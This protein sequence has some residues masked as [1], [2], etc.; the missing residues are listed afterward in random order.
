MLP[1]DF[2]QQHLDRVSRSFAFC[3]AELK[4]D[5]RVWVSLS[6]L[7]FRILD[8][9]E[10][11][12]WSNPLAKKAAFEDFLLFLKS[13]PPPSD[14]ERWQK[15]F[16]DSLSGGEAALIQVSD[17][18]FKDFDQ[19]DPSIRQDIFRSAQIMCH[20]M[21]HYAQQNPL[22]LSS[23]PEVNR[24]CFFVA[25]IVG[26]LL[27]QLAHRKFDFQAPVDTIYLNS[28]HF[29]L[30][31]QKTNLLKDQ[32]TDERAER[33]LIPNRSQIVASL[34]RN[35]KG[36]FDYICAIPLSAKEYRLFCSWSLFLGLF[37]LEWL[38]RNDKD[39]EITKIPRTITQKL[40][41]QIATIID[42]NSALEAFFWQHLPGAM[43]THDAKA[44]PSGS[45]DLSWF[46]ALYQGPLSL[47]AMRDLELL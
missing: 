9:V 22:R 41:S 14:H 15:S 24:Y 43:Q 17:L 28:H 38:S 39:S 19:L 8:T 4:G 1:I 10:D 6:Y 3:I 18:I 16:P 20:G 37:T 13:P 40:L 29:G 46:H 31:L 7:L 5:L 11:S 12:A 2:Y 26:E 35:A 45:E 34:G 21:A 27:T 42:S 44:D 25:G 33:F 30:F 32:W 23:L 36:A 47:P